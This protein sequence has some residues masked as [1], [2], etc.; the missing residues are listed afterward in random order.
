MLTYYKYSGLVIMIQRI[1]HFLSN[2]RLKRLLLISSV[3]ALS[4]MLLFVVLI[5]A[6][7]HYSPLHRYRGTFALHFQKRS[8]AR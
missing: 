5:A 7:R 4:A 2:I 8:S 1:K 3:L 6:L